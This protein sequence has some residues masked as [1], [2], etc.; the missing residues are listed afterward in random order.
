MQLFLV[1]LFCNTLVAVDIHRRSRNN[2]DNSG[3]NADF[4]FS[5]DEN[6]SFDNSP[7]WPENSSVD[8]RRTSFVQPP[9]F[10]TTASN[11]PTHPIEQFVRPVITVTTGF[12]S[13]SKTATQSAVKTTALQSNPN[14]IAS[15][16]I[17]L[18]TSPTQASIST[19][20]PLSVQA[21]TS[22]GLPNAIDSK[23]ERIASSFLVVL[24]AFL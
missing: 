7:W 12:A 16:T 4:N 14:E 9:P 8:F 17:S 11:V 6:D 21:T 13:L 15:Q 22:T 2:V 19:T 23:A 24:F 3:D 18:Q 10:T 1:L 5:S 20:A